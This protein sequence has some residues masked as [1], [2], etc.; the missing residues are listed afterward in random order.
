MLCEKNQFFNRVYFL[1]W[2]IFRWD[3]EMTFSWCL[4]PLEGLSPSPSILIISNNTP[5]LPNSYIANIQ[6]LVPG[7]VRREGKKSLESEKA[8]LPTI[9]IIIPLPMGKQSKS[10]LNPT[11]RCPFLQR[12]HQ[13]M[14][15]LRNSSMQLSMWFETFQL[16]QK[17]VSTKSRSSFVYVFHISWWQSSYSRSIPTIGWF[18]AEI[19]CILQTS[20]RRAKWDT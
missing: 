17:T 2:A 9:W 18:E 6:D 13:R 10:A 12:R 20:D 19:L 16:M 8:Y 4:F 1:T 7:Q 3:E 14:P 11:T 15:I 5:S